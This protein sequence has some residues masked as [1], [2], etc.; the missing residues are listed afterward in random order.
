MG[1]GTLTVAGYHRSRGI[2]EIFNF[3]G[4][5]AILHVIAGGKRPVGRKEFID[6]Q[7]MRGIFHRDARRRSCYVL[8]VIDQPFGNNAV[9][10]GL[11]FGVTINAKVHILAVQ[12]DDSL[13]RSFM[14]AVRRKFSCEL[15]H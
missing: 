4:R 10:F 6:G 15:R 7:V 2:T 1:C 11:A 3:A 13:A 5:L 9:I 14:E 12:G 8:T